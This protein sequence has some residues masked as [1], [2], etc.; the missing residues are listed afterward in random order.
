MRIEVMIVI[1]TIMILAAIFYKLLDRITLKSKWFSRLLLNPM[2]DKKANLFYAMMGKSEHIL[3]QMVILFFLTIAGF[4]LSKDITAFIFQHKILLSISYAIYTFVDVLR[5]RNRLN[6][7]DH[8]RNLPK[9][10]TKKELELYIT[11]E[12]NWLKY[13]LEVLSTY[14][15]FSPI[16]ILLPVAIKVLD[17]ILTSVDGNDFFEYLISLVQTDIISGVLLFILGLYWL[18]FSRKFANFR[19]RIDRINQYESA[20]VRLKHSNEEKPF[21]VV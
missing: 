10:H 14:K 12:K 6:A 20:L 2:G 3:R 16:S 1:F 11:Q 19:N 9:T 5:R 18:M 7:E 17:T 15:I 21:S 13:D 8:R 4:L